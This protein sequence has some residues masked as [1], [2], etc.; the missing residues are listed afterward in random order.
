MNKRI[1]FIFVNIL[2]CCAVTSAQQESSAAQSSAA[3]EQP[4]MVP[5]V[6]TLISA[7]RNNFNQG[8]HME[9][10]QKGVA[11]A[12]LQYEGGHYMG[13]F[14]ILRDID[15]NITALTIPGSSKSA[16]HY[17]TSKE[18]MK[19]YMRMQRPA[20][21]LDHLKLMENHAAACTVDSVKNDMLYNKTIYYY[22]VGQ[23]AKGNQVF[24]EMASKLTAA[25]EYDKIDEVYR[26]LIA[27]GRRS[28]SASLVAQSYRKYMAWKDSTNVIRHADEVKT[29]KKQIADNEATIADQDSSLT[30]RSV[31]ITGLL[32]LAGV[33]AAA[34]I[35]GAIILMR[36]ILLSRRQQKTIQ[37]ANDS[38][39]LKA[40]FIGSIAAQLEPTLNKLDKSKPEV[41]AVIDFTKHIQ[42][43]S[44][45]ENTMD[46]PVE[47]EDV[48]VQAFCEELMEPIHSLVGADVTIKVNAP[49]MTVNMNREY[50]AHILSHLLHNAAE[51]VGKEGTVT[52]E[53]K[54]RGAHSHQF[55]VSDTGEGI[56]EEQ[57]DDIFK[58]FTEV[59]DLT[60]G[61]GLGLPTCKQMALK[62]K[63]DL[64]IDPQF[65]KGTRF[66]LDLHD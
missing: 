37:L 6:R 7:Y 33:L 36:Y 57:R 10:V 30:Y 35:V 20:P 46:E 60:K 63:G 43:L 22:T 15:H 56:P 58:P 42:T 27:S 17:Y 31:I 24:E 54:K 40:K 5:G 29:L 19:M 14:D 38:N 16:M 65:T 49:K 4:A 41:K 52:L 13:A 64:E 18:R 23:N 11:A 51:F 8:K 53:Y 50:V 44:D 26:Q 55:L 9:G 39:A 12:R 32:I 28:N 2:F 1:A 66:I 25:K 47:K 61:D 45:V 3:T 59:R 34:L 62:M 21:A 48:Q